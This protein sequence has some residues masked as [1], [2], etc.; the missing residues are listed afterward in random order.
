MRLNYASVFLRL[1]AF[2]TIMWIPAR[3][4]LP[5]PWYYGCLWDKY[6]KV[7]QSLLLMLDFY[8]EFRPWP[9]L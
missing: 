3:M 2:E 5:S 4:T 7:S 6:P 9:C 8:W 1:I